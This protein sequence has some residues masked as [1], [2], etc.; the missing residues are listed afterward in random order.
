MMFL[1]QNISNN[2]VATKLLA[3]ITDYSLA[4]RELRDNFARSQELGTILT[5]QLF[6]INYQARSV[7]DNLKTVLEH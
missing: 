4:M 2:P 6:S 1:R 3:T 7:S 5:R